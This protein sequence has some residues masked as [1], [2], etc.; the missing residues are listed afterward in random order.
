M[1]EDLDKEKENFLYPTSK[2][3][4]EF[5]PGNL[6]F[7]AN[8]QEFAQRVSFLCG[9]ESSGKVSPQETYKEIKALWNQ[10]KQSKKAFLDDLDSKQNPSE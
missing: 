8:L 6:A 5:T 3:Y 7:N 4:G 2:Y 1:A 9:L 10:L